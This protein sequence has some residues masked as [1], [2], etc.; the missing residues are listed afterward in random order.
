MKKIKT[1]IEEGKIKKGGVNKRPTTPPP[2]P[3]KGQ[4][5]K[6]SDCKG[7]EHGNCQGGK[8]HTCNCKSF[9]VGKHDLQF[10]CEWA[11][12][13]KGGESSVCYCT[14]KEIAQIIA[15]ALNRK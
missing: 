11:V 12:Y 4:G 7:E 10:K 6:H 8:H 2:P 3:P 15:D 5:G 9:E 14:S 1:E 13:K